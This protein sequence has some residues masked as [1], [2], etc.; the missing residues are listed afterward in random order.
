MKISLYIQFFSKRC[1]MQN[2][3]DSCANFKKWKEQSKYDFGFVPLG[4]F[5]LPMTSN[6]SDCK[7]DDPVEE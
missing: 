4:D 2:K 5:V 3:F 7:V 6:T 1:V